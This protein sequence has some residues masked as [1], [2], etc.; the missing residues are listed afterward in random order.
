MKNN[1]VGDLI[2]ITLFVGFTALILTK[3]S[4]FMWMT[5]HPYPGG[6]VKF[7]LLA[8]MGELLAGRIVRREWVLPPAMFFRIAIWGL[9]GIVITLIFSIFSNGVRA[10]MDTGMLPFVGNSVMTALWISV[11]MNLTFAPT[12]MLAHRF[13]DSYLDLRFGER[14]RPV[15]AEIVQKMDL[16]GFLGFVVKKTIP[17]F[18]IPAHTITFLLPGDYRVVVAA[19][20]SIALGLLLAFAKRPAGAAASRKG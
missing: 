19:Y 9:L 4:F 7:G 10:A 12:M 18:W 20:L 8:T 6:F 14:K 2:W 16:V 11:C 15:L 5:A 13:T 1:R 17:L 3:S